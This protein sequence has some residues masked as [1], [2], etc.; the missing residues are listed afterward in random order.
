MEGFP[1]MQQ[2]A[3]AV[4]SGEGWS[5]QVADHFRSSA[6]CIAWLMGAGT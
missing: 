1:E 6:D 5:G 4:C 2:T 3:C